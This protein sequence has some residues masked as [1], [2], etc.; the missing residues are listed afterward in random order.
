MIVKSIRNVVS[1]FCS[2]YP[3]RDLQLVFSECKETKIFVTPTHRIL[4]SLHVRLK[5]CFFLVQ[6]ILHISTYIIQ[7]GESA[8]GGISDFPHVLNDSSVMEPSGT[9]YR[10]HLIKF[11]SRLLPCL[12]RGRAAVE[13][14]ALEQKQKESPKPKPE[15]SK[16]VILKC[17]KISFNFNSNV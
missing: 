6:D 14:R 13:L 1:F 4:V 5:T 2:K 12:Y 10:G 7:Y 3:E 8:K 11:S 15:V 9:G 17:Y 16:Q